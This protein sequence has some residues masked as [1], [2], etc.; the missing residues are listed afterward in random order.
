MSFATPLDPVAGSS[1]S[2]VP[3]GTK[4]LELQITLQENPVILR[5]G[6]DTT[7]VR[8]HVVVISR[9]IQPLRM[10]QVLLTGTKALANVQ[11]MGSTGSGNQ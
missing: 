11:Q 5:D 7:V 3:L 4:K 8:G 6:Q 1:S 10:I 2:S 9:E